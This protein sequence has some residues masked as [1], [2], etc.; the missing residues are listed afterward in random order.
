M[1]LFLSDAARQD[2]IDIGDTIAA[3]NPQRAASFVRE[4]ERKCRNLTS[5]PFAFQVVARY[6]RAG[7]R[8]AVHGRYSIFYR[9]DADAVIVV[10]V[11]HAAMDD[12]AAL[13]GQ[14]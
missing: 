10:R 3:D 4:I 7:L 12:E 8:R 13:K 9:V 2:L 11:L 14:P 5:S 6:E 1:K